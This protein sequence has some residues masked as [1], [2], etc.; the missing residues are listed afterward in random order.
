MHVGALFLAEASVYGLIGT[1]FGYIIG[2]GAGTVMTKLGWLGDVTL[3]YSG[4]SA[5]LTMTMMLTIVLL[6]A[7]WPARIAS[8]IASP[9]IERTWQVPPP[10]NGTIV[11]TLPFTINRATADDALARLTEFFQSH[12]DAAIGKFAAGEVRA[13]ESK[14]ARGLACEIWL[15]PFDLGIRQQMQLLIKEGKFKDIFEVEVH[16]TRESGDERT[17]HRANRP[18]LA[19]LRKQF[20][21][22]RTV[23]R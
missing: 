11:A 7:L 6:S 15:T 3:N 8:K 18:F 13:V 10:V 12:T 5:I 21:Q 22:W 23:S 1:V 17:W 9:S 19:E 14:T 4:T 16:L 2:Q 20:L